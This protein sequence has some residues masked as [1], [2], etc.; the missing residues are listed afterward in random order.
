MQ[1]WSYMTPIDRSAPVA[2][3][4]KIWAIRASGER[5]GNMISHM[6]LDLSILP[7]GRRMRMGYVATC[8]FECG[9][10]MYI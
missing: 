10:V 8:R 7:S 2:K 5:V 6:C 4:G 1:P 3:F 9:V